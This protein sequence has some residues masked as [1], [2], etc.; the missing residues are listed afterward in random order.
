MLKLNYY[1]KKYQRGLLFLI[2]CSINNIQDRFYQ[3]FFNGKQFEI[4]K[5]AKIDSKEINVKIIKTS[6]YFYIKNMDLFDSLFFTNEF[7]MDL[8]RKLME[9]L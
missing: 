3:C 8:R 6:S 7:K 5:L 2:Y 1:L 9:L 4:N